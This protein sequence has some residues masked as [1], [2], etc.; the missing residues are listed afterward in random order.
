MDKLLYVSMTGAREAMSAQTNHA[1]NLANVS[2]TGFKADFNQFRSMNVYG[3][4]H[5]SRVYAMTERPG[6]NMDTGRFITTGRD[7]DMALEGDGW[8]AVE[9]PDGSE[10]Y[11]KAGDFRRNVDGML[12]TGTGLPVIGNSGPIFI[13]EYERLTVGS[14]GTLSIQGLGEDASALTQID[15][16][17]VVSPGNNNLVKKEDGL[18]H[19]KTPMELD[20]VANV[21]VVNGMLESSNV[22]AVG[23]LT[24]VI[25]SSRLFELNVKMMKNAKDNDESAGRI[26]NG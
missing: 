18:F 20:P 4:V 23:E 14:D 12:T 25:A 17:K 9:K 19:T 5:P 21:R 8:F 2:T 24:E 10:A 7:L 1:N 26:L 15:R 11:T 3:E 16:I 13:P 6:T 22:N